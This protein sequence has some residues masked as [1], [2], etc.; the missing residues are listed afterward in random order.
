[1]PRPLASLASGQPRKGGARVV[2]EWVTPDL[3]LMLFRLCLAMLPSFFQFC[4]LSSQ[5][6][7]YLVP[8]L[9]IMVIREEQPSLARGH[10]IGDLAL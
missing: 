7:T 5:G 3:I 10:G 2:I 1:M 9:A 4:I 6:V 8:G